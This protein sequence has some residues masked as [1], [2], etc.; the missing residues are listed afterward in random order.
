MKRNAALV[1]PLLFSALVLSACETT[2]IPVEL[3]NLSPSDGATG[4][5]LETTVKA[6]FSKGVSPTL[7]AM[8]ANLFLEDMTD[9]EAPVKVPGKIAWDAVK[10]IAEF[11]PDQPLSYSTT[12]RFHVS[13][14]IAVEVVASFTTRDPDGLAVMQTNPAAGAAAVPVA[15]P[16]VLTFSRAFDPTTAEFGKTIKL[17]DVT[18]PDAPVSVPLAEKD[19]LA[20]DKDNKTLTLTP[21][22][23]Y[24]YS[25][26]L[27]ITVTPD[28]KA[29]DATSVSGFVPED[30]AAEFS[31]VDPPALELISISPSDAD[32]GILREAVP[33]SGTGLP[34]VATFSEGVNETLIDV[35]GDGVLDSGDLGAVVVEDLGEPWPTSNRPCHGLEEDEAAA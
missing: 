33:G 31:T 1:F 11:T 26:R 9:A 10:F 23:P 15:Q 2:K 35:N 12:Y 8:D 18:N 6:T 28:L 21:A 32:S 30:Y 7:V 17:E 27:R 4:I 19:G 5:P 25:R 22:A 20:P 16:V 3:A 29:T 24:G 14:V 34:I 13:K